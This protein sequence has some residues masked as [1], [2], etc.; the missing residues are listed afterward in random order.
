MGNTKLLVEKVLSVSSLNSTVGAGNVSD[1]KGLEGQDE[2]GTSAWPPP[3]LVQ[4]SQ[5]RDSQLSQMVLFD[6]DRMAA[7]I[8]NAMTNISQSSQ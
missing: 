8:T 6:Y 7:P 2:T 5:V 4:G 3:P 1:T